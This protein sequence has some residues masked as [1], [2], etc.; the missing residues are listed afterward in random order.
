M[1]EVKPR[2]K[3]P[4]SEQLGGDL[5]GEVATY[6]KVGLL[7]RSLNQNTGRVPDKQWMSS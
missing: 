3:A 5:E 4:K 2:T 1:P 7:Q 6:E